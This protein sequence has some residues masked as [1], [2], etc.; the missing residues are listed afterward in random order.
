MDDKE[1]WEGTPTLLYKK[2]T[3]IIDQV[4]PEL[5]RSNMWPKASNKLTSKINEIV[6]NL[7]ERGIEVITGGKDS[8]GNRIIQIINL[9][10]KKDSNVVEKGD[11]DEIL[12][13]PN[14]HRIGYSDTWEC[15]NCS[16]RGDIHFMEQHLCN[17]KN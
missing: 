14:I 12:F 8:E 1:H 5:K 15:K 2:L 9:K 16:Q 11:N 6:P 4:K 17:S 13:N 10:K 7:R 3:D